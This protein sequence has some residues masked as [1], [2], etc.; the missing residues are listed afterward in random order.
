MRSLRPLIFAHRGASGIAPTNTLV[1]FRAARRLGADGVELDVHLSA[2]GEVV[3]I[4]DFTLDRTT[5]GHWMVVEGKLGA[6]QA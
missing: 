6:W 4:H 5:D 1:A 2:D 3:V